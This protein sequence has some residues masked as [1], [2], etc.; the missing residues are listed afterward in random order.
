MLMVANLLRLIRLLG[1]KQM[2]I[3]HL[4]SQKRDTCAKDST[5]NHPSIHPSGCQDESIRAIPQG[6]IRSKDIVC[7]RGGSDGKKIHTLTHVALRK[8][9]SHSCVEKGFTGR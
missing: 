3:I 7:H 5:N 2:S 9:M 6:V 1:G 8:V 4:S